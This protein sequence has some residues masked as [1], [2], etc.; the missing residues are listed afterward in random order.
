MAA[1]GAGGQLVPEYG[2]PEPRNTVARPDHVAIEASRHRPGRA[3]QAGCLD[4]APYTADTICAENSLE[5]S[6]RT[7]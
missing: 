1:T 7:S 2:A 4:I 5:K 6:W 3:Q